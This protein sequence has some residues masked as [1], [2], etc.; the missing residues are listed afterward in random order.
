MSERGR[1]RGVLPEASCATTRSS[2]FLLRRGL[3]PDRE[4]LLRPG[5]RP[6]HPVVAVKAA[7]EQYQAGVWPLDWPVPAVEPR[8][9]RDRAER[10]P[11]ASGASRALAAFR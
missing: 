5:L 2:F 9:A 1:L 10:I 7:K 8:F 11:G 6:G 4:S 3:L